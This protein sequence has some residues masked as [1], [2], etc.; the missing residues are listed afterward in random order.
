AAEQRRVRRG[1]AAEEWAEIQKVRNQERREQLEQ[2][3]AKRAE[4]NRQANEQKLRLRERSA[5]IKK[6]TGT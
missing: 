6:C 4:C 5:F 3:A 2:Q 1:I